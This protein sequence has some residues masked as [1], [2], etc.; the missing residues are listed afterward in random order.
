MKKVL[1]GLCTI[2][3]LSIP[4]TAYAAL[5]CTEKADK[6]YERCDQNW[7]GDT[8]ADGLG[9]VACKSGCAIAEAGCIIGE[10]F[11]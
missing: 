9:R 3:L 4:G 7:K 6:C 1:I 10:W 11:E 8:I 2:S 5:T